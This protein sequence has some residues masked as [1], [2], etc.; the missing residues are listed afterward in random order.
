MEIN[1]DA[2]PDTVAPPEPE[3][4]PPDGAAFPPPPVFPPPLLLFPLFPFL[5]FFGLDFAEFD[6]KICK[7][8][9]PTVPSAVRPFVL[10]KE[11]TASLVNSPK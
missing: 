9:A 10:W 11:S 3:E 4:N 5:L 6:C 1:A 2:E 7:V 8:F